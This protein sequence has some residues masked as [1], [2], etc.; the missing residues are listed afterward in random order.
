MA[1]EWLTGFEKSYMPERVVVDAAGVPVGNVIHARE[2]SE[3]VEVVF[4]PVSPD[5]EDLV[6]GED[7]EPLQATVIIPGGMIIDTTEEG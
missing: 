6:G 5:G 2:T 7:F 1:S 4:T 3:G